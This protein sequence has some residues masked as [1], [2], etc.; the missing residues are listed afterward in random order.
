[1]R[2]LALRLEW[3]RRSYTSAHKPLPFKPLPF[4]TVA[5]HAVPRIATQCLRIATDS[6]KQRRTRKINMF[7]SLIV[8]WCMLMCAIGTISAFAQFWINQRRAGGEERV[9]IIL[10]S[11]LEPINASISRIVDNYSV[12]MQKELSG[13]ELSSLEQCVPLTRHPLAD[14]VTVIDENGQVHFPR[15]VEA[16]NTDRRSLIDEAQQLLLEQ[17]DFRLANNSYGG[18]AIPQVNSVSQGEPVAIRREDLNGSNLGGF[19]AGGLDESVLG[20]SQQERQAQVVESQ[21]SA[22]SKLRGR[23]YYGNSNRAQQQVAVPQ[24]SG[25]PELPTLQNNAPADLP[26]A[27]HVLGDAI[28]DPNSQLTLG[29]F[30]QPNSSDML[31]YN[32]PEA[33]SENFGWMTWYHRRG[34]VL[35]FWWHQPNGYRTLIGLPRARWMADIVAAMPDTVADKGSVKQ[36]KLKSISLN[37]GSPL[38][39]ASIKQLVD[40]EGNVIY[41]WGEAPDD[42]WE[43]VE[44]VSSA[45]LDSV[46]RPGLSAE[47]PVVNPLEGWRVRIHATDAL[48][49][50]LAGDDMVLPIW[51]AVG[52]LSLALVLGGLIVTLNLNRQM[53]LASNRVSFVNQVSHELRTPLTN[54]CMYADLLAKDLEQAE[55]AEAGTLNR[56]GVIQ[57]ES[58]RL[59]RLINNVLEY[60]RSGSKPKAVRRT[61][62]CMDEVLDE[63]LET[64]L[65][66]LDELGFEVKRDLGA[67]QQRELDPDA[68]EQILVNLIGNAEKYAVGGKLLELKTW[69]KGEQLFLSVKDDGPGVPKQMAQK[70][71]S[72]FERVSDKLETPAGTGIGLAIV[73]EI[74]RRHGGDCRLENSQQGAHFV[75][76]INAPLADSGQED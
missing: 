45:S 52:S 59:N 4:A 56:L 64:F 24:Q 72:P 43:W 71:F 57:N 60:A 33:L 69:A 10:R 62:A 5:N 51:L 48:V 9:R 18:P 13:C 25:S 3:K 42:F 21:E 27:E 68:V 37:S 28:Q 76:E 53:R 2:R 20:S 70:I 30:A 23:S 12:A 49:E 22:Y 34:M 6:A 74:A 41:Q 47:L 40:V 14:F 54:I 36:P 31:N 8:L 66:R 55:D 16:K 44:N 35:G 65:P 73:R 29:D 26:D 50:Q 61:A 63:V 67:P 15:N 38:K 19:G 46:D 32:G 17:S 1:M 11:Q 75:C 39:S 58:R 7:R